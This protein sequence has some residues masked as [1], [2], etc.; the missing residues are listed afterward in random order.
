[1]LIYRQISF[2]IRRSDSLIFYPLNPFTTP[3]ITHTLTFSL[4]SL[5]LFSTIDKNTEAG[6]TACL[7]ACG[8]MKMAHNVGTAAHSVGTAAHH[9]GTAAGST[10]KHLGTGT[11]STIRKVSPRI[12]S[13]KKHEK[14]AEE[15]AVVLETNLDE[16]QVT[17]TDPG[18]A[19]V[20]MAELSGANKESLGT[21]DNVRRRISDGIKLGKP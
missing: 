21:G 5:P 2:Q 20:D 7:V 10:M 19:G 18:V 16:S 4:L 1:M 8:S 6:K 12:F 3:S 11:A 17:T 9:V 14:E 15:D 13:K